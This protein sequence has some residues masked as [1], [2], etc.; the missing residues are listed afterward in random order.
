MAKKKNIHDDDRVVKFSYKGYGAGSKV[1]EIVHF[2]YGTTDA[3]I[4]EAFTDWLYGT[5]GAYWADLEEGE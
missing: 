2:P 5:S 3:D 1:T 4:D